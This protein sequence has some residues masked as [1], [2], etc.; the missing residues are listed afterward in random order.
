MCRAWLQ[1]PAGRLGH[2]R[3]RL[4]VASVAACH[5][6]PAVVENDVPDRLLI[7][8]GLGF[9]DHHPGAIEG[10]DQFVGADFLQVQ[11]SVMRAEVLD[12]EFHP[13]TIPRCA[14]RP[15]ACPFLAVRTRAPAALLRR[16]L[17]LA[18][19]GTRFQARFGH[20]SLQ[21]LGSECNIS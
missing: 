1:S 6:T 17:R 11:Q 13:G 18:L 3:S 21:S 19:I 12:R 5:L 14:G 20:S 15:K 9:F 2:R 10:V 4:R 7:A 16:P 8:V